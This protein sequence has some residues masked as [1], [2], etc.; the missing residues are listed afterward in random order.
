MASILAQTGTWILSNEPSSGI[1]GEAQ[2]FSR[3]YPLLPPLGVAA[4]ALAVG[5][6]VGA[7][8]AWIVR[9]LPRRQADSL[10]RTQDL[11]GLVGTV[12]IPFD[13]SCKG[14]IRV[15][16]KGAVV[17]FPAF[18]TEESKGFVKGEPVLIMG[19]ENNNKVWLV[20][21]TTLNY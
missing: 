3:F 2:R 5:L 6:S 10:V 13:A 20:S 8:I 17:D 9:I 4:L 15:S 1:T 19:V 21:E 18:T 14:K 16:V 7:A 11:V 12:E